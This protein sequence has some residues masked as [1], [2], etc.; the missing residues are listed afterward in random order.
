MGRVKNFCH[1][2]NAVPRPYK[3]RQNR[4]DE[5]PQWQLY[6]GS[7]KPKRSDGSQEMWSVRFIGGVLKFG[8]KQEKH[9]KMNLAENEA[10]KIANLMKQDVFIV[11][12]NQKY[13]RINKTIRYNRKL[14]HA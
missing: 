9:N 1:V 6:V 3:K 13:W 11:K 2:K 8:D 10:K 5:H 14:N 12:T 7:N 4:R